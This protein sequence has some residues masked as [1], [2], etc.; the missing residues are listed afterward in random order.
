[1][2][3]P[4]AYVLASAVVASVGS[5]AGY[6][7]HSTPATGA[8][9]EPAQTQAIASGVM[10]SF[11]GAQLSYS[12]SGLFRVPSQAPPGD[13]MVAAGSSLYGCTWL[14]LKANDGKPKSVIEDGTLNRGGFNATVTVASSDK[15]IQFIG[16]CTWSRVVK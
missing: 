13:Y 15:Y 6:V 1:V 5:V 8:T 16:D 12:G 4:W 14:R 9:F 11:P 7:L 3:K 10:Q 2:T